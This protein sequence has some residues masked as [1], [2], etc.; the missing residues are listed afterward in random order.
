MKKQFSIKSAKSLINNAFNVTA[1]KYETNNI[2][3]LDSGKEGTVCCP[4]M[5]TI[6]GANVQKTPVLS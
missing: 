4:W 5:V 3:R 1:A 2:L 6:I